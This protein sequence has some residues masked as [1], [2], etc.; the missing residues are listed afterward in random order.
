MDAQN[1]EQAP[2]HGDLQRL[3]D[4]LFATEKRA[5][6]LDALI[7]AQAHDLSD[8]L[9]EVVSLLPPMSMTRP[10][11]CDQINSTLAAHGWGRRYGIVS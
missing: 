4:A 5:N 1:W 2:E 3:I 8:D 11:F 9:I 10:Q 7:L 6:R